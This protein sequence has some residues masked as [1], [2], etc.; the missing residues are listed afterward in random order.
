MKKID[1]YKKIE[2]AKINLKAGKTLEANNIFQELLKTNP[3]EELCKLSAKGGEP[4]NVGEKESV[5]IEVIGSS[6]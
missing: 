2:A 6:K 5:S 4:Q 3:N 1:L